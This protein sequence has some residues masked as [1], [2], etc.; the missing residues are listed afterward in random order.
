VIAEFLPPLTGGGVTIEG[1]VDGNGEPDVTLRASERLS[2]VPDKAGLQLASSGNRLHALTLDGFPVGVFIRPYWGG[3]PPLPREGTFADNVV[4]GLVIRGSN[5][6]VLLPIWGP[7]CGLPFG[8]QPCASDFRFLNTTISGN[9]IEAGGGIVADLHNVGGGRIAGMAV[10]ANTIRMGV[11]H[12]GIGIGFLEGGNSTGTRISDVLIARNTIDGVNADGGIFV[13]AGLQRAQANTIERVRILDN[14]VHL[15][16]QR[17]APCCFTIVLEAGQDTWAEKARPVHYP[18]RNVLREVRVA[19][20]SVSGSVAA[21][22]KIGAGIDAGG[23]ENR[24]ENVRVEHNVVRS[25]MIG[26][27]VYL[28]TGQILP[29]EG[30]YARGN[31]IA[32]ITIDSNRITTGRGEPL[33]GETLRR[34]AGGVVLLGGWQYSRR[35]VIRNV[36]IANN[37]IATLYAG[38]RLIGGIGPTARGNRVS[39]IRLA[40]NRITGA[41]KRVSVRPDIRG[42]SRNRAS[43]R[44]C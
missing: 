3:P 18:D 8:L 35:G 17:S 19:G 40:R 5:G 34:S 32:G 28:W 13:A 1:D 6:I 15:T 44:G 30:T 26:K 20:N 21:G 41:R 9:T 29:F 25:T 37:R 38:V 23:S 33:E 4:S 16:R 43:L 14:R 7:D 12:H 36:R 10:T 27:G 39:C 2:G 42:A 31:R 22:V 11:D 24:I